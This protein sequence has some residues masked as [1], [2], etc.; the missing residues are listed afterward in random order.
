MS[1]LENKRIFLLVIILLTLVNLGFVLTVILKGNFIGDGDTRGERRIH[2][3]HFMREEIGFSEAQMEQF[4]KSRIEFRE[5]TQPLHDSLRVL[6]RQLVIEATSV[7]PDSIKCYL[8][9]RQIGDVY[10]EIKQITSLHMMKVSK[11]ATP[12]QAAKLK[13]LYHE[14]FDDDTP[15]PGQGHGAQ[16]R[17]RQGRPD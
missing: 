9:S 3:R 13:A 14:M 15:P 2:P 16:F 5:Q 11:I 12:Q 17:H 4:K 7:R 10:T 6:N 8:I 1:K